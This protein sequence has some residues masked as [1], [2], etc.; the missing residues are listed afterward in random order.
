M[1]AWALTGNPF[2]TH[3]IVVVVAFVLAVAGAYYLVR[4]LIGQ[5]EAAAVAGGALRVLPVHLRA[6]RAHPAP[7]D[8]RDSPSRCSP[9]TASSIAPSPGRALTLGVVL[10]A[11]ALVCAYYGIF[12]ALMIGLGTLFYAVSRRLWRS[13]RVL[14][15]SASPRWSRSA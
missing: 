2:L 5:P 8:R 11:Q 10:W 14:G 9:S 4:Y 1:P 15:S 3:N 12:A 6:H 7:D 13:P